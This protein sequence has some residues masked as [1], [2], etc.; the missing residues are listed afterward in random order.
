M[1]PEEQVRYRQLTGEL[2]RLSAVKQELADL[3]A[4][5]YAREGASKFTVD[6]E[7]VTLSTAKNGVPY[8]AARSRE[9]EKAT[10]PVVPTSSTTPRTKRAI[11]DGQVVNIPVPARQ[12]PRGRIIQATAVLRSSA[13]VDDTSQEF[14]ITK[15]QLAEG[16]RSQ[17]QYLESVI[18]GLPQAVEQLTPGMAELVPVMVSAAR[19]QIDHLTGFADQME[20]DVLADLRAAVASSTKPKKKRARWSAPVFPDPED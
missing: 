10:R 5:V 13:R 1:T 6:G 4:T 18:E 15:E 19:E 7:A 3:A 11:V 16:A 8:F 12:P 17:A 20:N 9:R 14:S 2:S